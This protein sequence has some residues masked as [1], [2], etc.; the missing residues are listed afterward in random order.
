MSAKGQASGRRELRDAP[1]R[2]VDLPA[3][4]L[5]P[6]S[7]EAEQGILGCV[8][9]SPLECMSEC[10]ELKVQP[11]WFYELRHRTLF[12]ALE[13]LNKKG[14]AIDLVTVMQFLKDRTQLEDV[15]GLG[16]LSELPDKVPSAA[17]LAYYVNIVAEKFRL[18][19]LLAIGIGTKNR[20]LTFGQSG[21]ETVDGL[22]IDVQSEVLKLS[23]EQTSSKEVALKVTTLEVIDEWENYH[24]GKPQMIGVS[25]GLDYLD[26]VTLGIGGDNGNLIVLSG[27]PGAG[28]TSMALQ[29]GMHA[30]LDYVW[31]EPVLD[32][33]GQLQYK[34]DDRGQEKVVVR[35]HR[36]VPV[37]VFSMEMARKALVNRMLFQRAN[38]D[39]Q[40]WRTG[41]FIQED[42]NK[43]TKATSEIQRGEQIFIDDSPRLTIE[44]LKARA[45]RMF[46]QHGVKLFIVDYIQL[47]RVAGARGRH[48]DRV[49][50]LAEISAELQLLGKEMN[51]PFIVL[52]QMNRDSDKEPNRLPRLSDLKDC[53]A[54]EQDAD[55]VMLLYKQQ[56]K[57]DEEDSYTAQ[58]E[59]VYGKDWSQFPKRVNALIAK[60]RYGPA[61]KVVNLLFHGSS[62]RFEDWGLW[63]KGNGYKQPALGESTE[64]NKGNKGRR[65][66]GAVVDETDFKSAQEFF[67]EDGE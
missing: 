3:D 64:G 5:P 50:E 35:S 19:R 54:I 61:D 52:A 40:R 60:N 23:E 59:K 4:L 39:M 11:E 21:D 14:T 58:M 62:T 37:G 28:K 45:R 18:R 43:L 57:G 48:G 32:D 44:T 67:R 30:A 27:R 15:G 12:V 34:P 63:Q 10:E 47:M 7:A 65:E 49:Q 20:V 1:K 6:Y 22:V 51:V 31:F 16:Y 42:F 24:R 33:R 8:L 2:E 17:N 25:T 66:A 41:F 26:K 9:Q 36:G 55:L 53:G 56:M 38:A 13:E 46:R 29:V